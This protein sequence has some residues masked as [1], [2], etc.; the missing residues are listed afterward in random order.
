MSLFPE[1]DKGTTTPSVRKKRLPVVS[2]RMV[3][4]GSLPYNT[5]AIKSPKDAEDLLRNFIE[6]TDRE[7]FVEICLNTKNEPI[8]IH[9]V[10]IGTLNSTSVHPREVFKIAILSNAAS[11]ILGH[12][13]P[14]GNPDPSEDDINVTRRLL[15]AGEILGI[16]ILDHIII[17]SDKH[18][19]LKEMGLL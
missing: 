19:S 4:D 11:I 5:K 15:S 12:N 1:Y 14:S 16:T 8:M 3:R 7:H 17:G 10:S 6:D 13:H 2:I 18:C 9:T